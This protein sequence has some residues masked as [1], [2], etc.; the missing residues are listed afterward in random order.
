MTLAAGAADEFPS[1]V[2][3]PCCADTG[4]VAAGLMLLSAPV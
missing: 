1:I 2:K 4:F 3:R